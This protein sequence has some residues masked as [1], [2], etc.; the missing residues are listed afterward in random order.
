MIPQ[1][2]IY[3]TLLFLVFV[4]AV[5]GALHQVIWTAFQHNPWLN[6]VILCDPAV[7][8]LLQYSP[9]PASQARGA[10]D[11]GRSAPTRPASRC[12]TRRGCWRRSPPCWASASAAAARHSRPSRCAICWTASARRL[13]E[14]RDISG[15][16]RNLLIFL[17]LLGTFWGL[18]QAIGSISGVISSLTIGSGDFAAVFNEFKAGPAAAALRAWARPSAPRC[19]ASPA[20]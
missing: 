12:R 13:D 8:H 9:H 19:S 20:R 6:G 5:V 2:F 1:R 17:G 18:I 11:R 7:R 16:L 15:Y 14:N 3:R 10:L 4:A